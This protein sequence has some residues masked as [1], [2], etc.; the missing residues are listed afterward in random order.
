MG[1][2]DAASSVL[3]LAALPTMPQM[4]RFMRQTGYETLTTVKGGKNLAHVCCEDSMKVTGMQLVLNQLLKHAMAPSSFANARNH[5]GWAPLHIVAS[6][7]DKYVTRPA[8]IMTLVN[9][10]A[11]VEAKRGPQD[12][13]P[14]HIACST[15]HVDGAEALIL[16]GADPS[17]AS[18]EGTTCYDLAK[19]CSDEMAQTLEWVAARRGEGTTGSDRFI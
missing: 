16:C 6:G 18:K 3:G 10:K 2:G 9:M 4:M 12:M 7:K 13:T 14:L 19:M 1:G 5:W 15:A 17:A 11:D 8:M